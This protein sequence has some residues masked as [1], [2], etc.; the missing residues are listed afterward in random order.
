MLALCVF[1]L[2]TTQ[3]LK[4]RI[5]LSRADWIDLI[6]HDAEFELNLSV[7]FDYR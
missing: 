6:R 4:S 7:I 1:T 5:E 2:S 3:Q